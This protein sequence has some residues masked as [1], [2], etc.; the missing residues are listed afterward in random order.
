MRCLTQYG[1]V[2]MVVLISL[3]AANVT[4]VAEW[5]EPANV[6]AC[7][8]ANYQ[9]FQDAAWT[10]LPSIGFEYVFINVP[11]P[12]LV[13][14]VRRRLAE[15]GLS[16]AVL[17]GS[18]ELSMPSSVDELAVQL[19]TCERVGEHFPLSRQV[20]TWLGVPIKAIDEKTGQHRGIT[21]RLLSPY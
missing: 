1:V 3:I 18:T 14:A 8:L 2:L 21:R 20:F 13:E 9:E 4:V 17:R 19:E 15:H 5:A 7:R 16:V 10:H 6:L 11:S 12:D